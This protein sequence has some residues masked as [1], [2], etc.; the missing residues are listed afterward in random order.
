MASQ[1]KLPKIVLL[2]A[3]L[4]AKMFPSVSLE[5]RQ[6]RFGLWKG[7]LLRASRLID[8]DALQQRH[9][10]LNTW[11][12]EEVQQWKDSHLASCNAISVAVR[13]APIFD[14]TY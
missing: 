10:D 2:L 6:I 3:V 12:D 14:I 13:A 5:Y 4:A 8:S 9:W 1:Q 7:E 11:K